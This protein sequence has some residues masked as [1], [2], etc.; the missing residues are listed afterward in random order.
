[1]HTRATPSSCE[2][3]RSALCRASVGLACFISKVFLVAADAFQS[4]TC[5]KRV[6][7]GRKSQRIWAHRHCNLRRRHHIGQRL[8]PLRR[9][10]RCSGILWPR[11]IWSRWWWAQLVRAISVQTLCDV[12]QNHRVLL[13]EAAAVPRQ[14]DQVEGPSGA[15]QPQTRAQEFFK[16]DGAAATHIHDFEKA[17]RLRDVNIDRLQ[18]V[19]DWGGVQVVVNLLE[20]D[21]SRCIEIQRFEQLPGL[22]HAV[23]FLD[24][25]GALH[26]VLDEGAGNDVHDAQ[27]RKGEVQKHSRGRPTQGR[28]LQEGVHQVAP[29]DTSCEALEQ[30]EHR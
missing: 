23:D 15:L 16:V 12:L 10:R 27:D 6:I 19:L 2:N 25:R 3:A 24:L 30:R 1:M 29:I 4:A 9:L 26:R 28:V 22:A 13:E 17:A 14:E 8:K 5:V 20:G 11:P 21:I 7:T 18:E